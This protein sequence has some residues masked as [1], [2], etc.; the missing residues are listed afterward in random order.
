MAQPRL[1][2]LAA[3]LALAG[4]VQGSSQVHVSPEAPVVEHGG[5]LW[6]N[7]SHT[8]N[9]SSDPGGLETPLTKSI[10]ERGPG[11]T[12]FH[13]TNITQWN[14]TLQCYV[15]C[16]GENVTIAS[17]NLSVYRV[18]ERVVLEPLPAMELGRAYNLTCRVLNVAPVR[19]LSVTLLRGGRA[20]HTETF[21]TRPGNEPDSVTVTHEISPGRWDHGQ[22]VTCQASLDLAPRGPRLQSNSSA[23]ELRVYALPAAPW[24]EAPPHVEEGAEASAR[25]GVA[26]I[27]PAAEARLSL[28]LGGE[29]L[30]PPLSTSGD[31][32]SAQAPLPFPAPGEYELNCT[33]AVGPLSRSAVRRVLLYRL[34]QPLLEISETQTL[35]GSNVTLTCH[36]A[37]EPPRALLTL[38]DPVRVL[39]SGTEPLGHVWLTARK[40]DNGRE[41]TCEARP[42]PDSTNVKST[43]SRLSVVYGPRLDDSGCPGN[44]TWAAGTEQTLSCAALGNPPPDVACTKDGRQVSTTAPRRVGS[45][46][47]GTYV[48]EAKNTLGRARREVTVHVEHP[49]PNY[50]LLVLLPAVLG[51]ALALAAAYGLHYRA[52]KIRTYRLKQQQ[53]Q[54]QQ[55]AEE[56]KLNGA[57]ENAPDPESSV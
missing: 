28:T 56:V 30:D 57:A 5:S 55:Q 32:A 22:Q 48:C 46:D 34:P 49:K 20:L 4:S 2:L 38:R 26:G 43:A 13:L 33:V 3:W 1:L 23:A 18:P 47:A 54:Q 35:A 14:P 17:T 27:F 42:A 12:A 36:S 45:E 53:Q 15:A 52:H 8:C 41:F 11:W 51:I 29:R 7:C 25:C 44:R 50:L 21:R 9:Y 37:M 40:Q 16:P 39:A 10:E 24:L 6:I 19:H 31:A